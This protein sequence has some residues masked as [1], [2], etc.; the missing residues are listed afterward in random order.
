M[1][2]YK[3]SILTAFKDSKYIGVDMYTS[4]VVFSRKIPI[5]SQEIG[6]YLALCH[7]IILASK[8][9]KDLVI[10]TTN[11]S[12]IFLLLNSFEKINNPPDIFLKCIEKMKNY[13][14]HE[15]NGYFKLKNKHIAARLW[16]NY[17]GDIPNY[18]E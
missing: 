14:F 13:T 16:P 9:S 2:K 8:G 11:E 10:Y 7:A 1:P 18:F 6:D 4:K 5:V 17:W 3:N 12:A 15:D